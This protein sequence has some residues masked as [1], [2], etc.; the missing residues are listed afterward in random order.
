MKKICI[1]S[2]YDKDGIVDRF[3]VN[4]LK[5]ISYYVDEILLVSNG[6]ITPKGKEDLSI[7]DSMSI[8]ERENKG[9]DISGI[10]EALFKISFDK[11]KDYSELL[12]VNNSIM[13]P[14]YP[15]KEMFD[16][17]NRRDLD[18]WGITSYNK[19]KGN[20]WGDSKLNYIPEHLQSYFM[21]IGSKMLNSKYFCDYWTNLSPLST[22]EEAVSKHEVVFTKYFSD[23]GFKWDSYINTEDLNDRTNYHL[24]YFP[25]EIV[26]NRKCPVFKR[27]SFTVDYGVYLNITNRNEAKDLFLYL[28]NIGYDTKDLVNNI[29]RTANQLDVRFNLGGSYI[30]SDKKSSI[31]YIFMINDIVDLDILENRLSEVDKNI[32]VYIY[33]TTETNENLYIDG[34]SIIFGERNDYLKYIKEIGLKY[35]F[36]GF[37][38]IKAYGDQARA[39]EILT[40]NNDFDSLVLK[41]NVN[42]KYLGMIIPALPIYL[43]HF[44]NVSKW[45]ENSFT[46]TKDILKDI[47]VDVD[48]NAYKVPL[49]PS[50]GSFIIN[51]NILKNTI[52]DKFSSKY[53]EIDFDTLSKV[54]PYLIQQNNYLTYMVGTTNYINSLLYK[55]VYKKEDIV[56]YYKSKIYYLIDGNC[57]ED[58]T[59]S[60]VI[61]K[62]GNSSKF[63][64]TFNIDYTSDSVRFDPLEGYGV[65]TKGISVYINNKKCKASKIISVN[66]YTK[67]NSSIFINTDPQILM[68]FE[69][70]KGD[71]L[72]I[73]IEEFVVFDEIKYELN[74]KGKDIGGESL[75]RA[76]ANFIPKKKNIFRSIKNRFLKIKK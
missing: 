21:V 60:G 55:L 63:V 4:I 11:L 49:G 7:I 19:E 67:G 31:A 50:T 74:T 26:K 13:G 10:K 39:S 57:S 20:P 65:Y 69:V 14:V 16:E 58:L 12:I 35:D 68:D 52:W 9:F 47:G 61:K 36:I 54:L 8:I 70:N 32:D 53:G 48:L 56:N 18:F 43:T 24:M 2:F 15:F 22:Y 44:G 23:L 76:I 62:E 29:T 66:G 73:E 75:N 51:S 46:V 33:L 45:S 6:E 64:V 71:V 3:V 37:I 27:K 42:A 17:M 25:M 72:K 41:S 40:F 38:S 5:E 28:D 30:D 34:A 1:Y 59:S